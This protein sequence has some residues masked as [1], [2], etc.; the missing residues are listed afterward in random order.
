M[1]PEKL[2]AVMVA[3]GE[4]Y[5]AMA[6]ITLPRA[7]RALGM[8]VELITDVAEPYEAKL[9][10]LDGLAD[11]EHVLLLDTDLVF[12]GWD[13]S[14]IQ[15][16]LFNAAEDMLHPS[17]PGTAAI[18]KLMPYPKELTFNT[19][20]WIAPG[21][22]QSVFQAA[23]LSARNELKDFPY[24]LWEQTPLNFALQ[25]FRTPRTW[26][27]AQRFNWQL[28]PKDHADPAPKKGTLVVH[29]MEGKTPQAKL[30]RVA[31]Y[32]ERFPYPQ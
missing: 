21:S 16:G 19:G 31:K 24:R 28:S 26:L 12:F 27:S 3:T 17:W 29:L 1:K 7:E 5:Q 32:C 15:P 18:L 11:D 22:L 13:W 30:E 23:L 25:A 8:P 14:P 6:A 9:Q 20:L 10:L 4:H 2:R